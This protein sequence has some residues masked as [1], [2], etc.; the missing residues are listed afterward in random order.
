MSPLKSPPSRVVDVFP[1]EPLAGN[2]LA[3]F[4]DAAGF[5]GTTMQKIARELNLAETVFVLPATRKDCA[6]RVRIFTPAKEMPFAGHP[7]IG[8]AFVLLQEKIV[9]RSASAFMLEE[10]VGPVPLRIEEGQ[11][12]LIWL[13]MPPIPEGRC[14]DSALCA[15]ALGLEPQNLLPMK[16]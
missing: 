3:V 12:P 5:S 7:T 14:Y 13:R 1:T 2:P 10:Q 11:R 16:Q 6:A 4:P 9:A 8:T 15:K